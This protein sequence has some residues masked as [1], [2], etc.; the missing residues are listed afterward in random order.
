MAQ[1]D[2]LFR[3]GQAESASDAGHD[4]DFGLIPRHDGLPLQ[5]GG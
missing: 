5:L 1:A 2:E 3:H 4:D